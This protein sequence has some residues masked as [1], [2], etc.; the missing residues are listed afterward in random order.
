[1]GEKCRWDLVKDTGEKAGG[2][3][4]G[5]PLSQLP[6]SWLEAPWT[7]PPEVSIMP[8]AS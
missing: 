3:G 1:M 7:G 2:P 5:P 8:D 6:Y 4:E